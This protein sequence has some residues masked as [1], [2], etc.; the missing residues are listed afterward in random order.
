MIP[1]KGHEKK[2]D[3]S[4]NHLINEKS[5]YLQQHK[6][7]PVDWHPWG[8]NAFNKALKANKP[9]FL[10]IGY[11]TCHWCHV[12]AHESFED[13]EVGEMINEV[14]VPIKVD[15]EERP[16]IDNIYMNVCQM[17]T[18]GGGWPLTI[19]LTPEKKPFFAGT[20]FPKESQYGRPGLKDIIIKVKELW[21]K[22]PQEA[23]QS[24]DKIVDVLKQISQ[25]TPGGLNN[26]EILEETY[27]ALEE[28]FDREYGGFGMIQ[29]FPS[30]TNL[31]F[32]LRYWKRTS[33]DNSL[34]MV[35]HTLDKMRYGGIYDHVGFGF[36]R[37]TV[38][39]QWL[40][41]HF[42]KMLYDQALI[43]MAYLEAFQITEN[44]LYRKTAEEIFEYVIRDMQ[45]PEGGFYSAEDADSEGEEGKF[46]LW[47]LDELDEILG[48]DVHL[49][50]ELYNIRQKGN[51]EEESTGKRNGKNIFHLN[52]S[53]EKFSAQKGID[54]KELIK[55]VDENLLK[56]F[57]H[58]KERIHP[59][60]DDKILVDW[61]GLII[62][63]LSRGFQILGNEKYSESAKKAA[64]FILSEMYHEQRLMHR[65]KD[66][67]SAVSGNLDDYA[68][69]IWGLIELYQATFEIK[70]LSAAFELN[71]TLNL[72]F[73]DKE[74]GGFYFTADD[75]EEII[76][77][78]K[79]SYDSALPSGN[80]VQ[81]L[82]LLKMGRI[83]EDESFTKIARGIERYFSQKIVRSPLAHTNMINAIDFRLGPS[84]DIIISCKDEKKSAFALSKLKEVLSKNYIPNIVSLDITHLDE[85]FEVHEGN[86]SSKLPFN[87]SESLKAKKPINGLCAYYICSDTDCKPPLT[88]IEDLVKI[89]NS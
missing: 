35:L 69:L 25:N 12:M 51:F 3:N 34:D 23:L 10:S 72:H 24:A 37:Y 78:K 20:Y 26:E 67:E 57:K 9:V 70:Y 15:R 21:E 36:H 13:A 77:R 83:S 22:N 27:R 61:N 42:E 19:I 1:E 63:A 17:M 76:I 58:R 81:M 68:F 54:L 41:P 48:E 79:E 28:S 29:K 60:K 8:E 85:Y 44:Q 89:L 66:G 53:L 80:S 33:S 73:L 62:A 4:Y 31:Y 64:D 16:E 14:F 11:S 30:P 47:A 52:G 6:N 74:S 50:S 84:Y 32:L 39:P 46:Y 87:N 75:A 49:I 56:L 5:P 7:N 86:T 59:Q 18:G 65:Y 82:N 40:V 45:S 43:S 55:K 88:E 71:E 2:N 38:D